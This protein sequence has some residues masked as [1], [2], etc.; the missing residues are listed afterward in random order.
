MKGKFAQELGQI[1]LEDR[2]IKALLEKKYPIFKTKQAFFW[3]SV[4]G[5]FCYLSSPDPSQYDLAFLGALFI[6]SKVVHTCKLCFQVC[7]TGIGTAMFGYKAFEGDLGARGPVE[8]FF[9]KNFTDCPGRTSNSYN[10]FLYKNLNDYDSDSAK[11]IVMPSGQVN[12]LKVRELYKVYGIPLPDYH[13]IPRKGIM[14]FE[15]PWS[16]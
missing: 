8:A 10:R 12:M 13:A 14:K 7:A 16:K 9:D 2:E 6:A 4:L 1:S 3:F 11:S 15:W 5:C